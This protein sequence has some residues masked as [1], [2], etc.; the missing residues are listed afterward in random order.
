MRGR[1]MQYFYHATTEENFSKI[2]SDGI[3]KKSIDGI[4]YITKSKEDSLRFISL[5]AFGK[6]IIVLELKLPDESKVEETFDHSYAFF[7]CKSFGYPDNIDTKCIVNAY[8]YL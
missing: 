3:I 4:V 7:K 2:L 5:R 8:K 6:P 1:Y